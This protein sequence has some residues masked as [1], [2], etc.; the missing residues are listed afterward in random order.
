[1]GNERRALAQYPAAFDGVIAVGATGPDDVW[2][3]SFPWDTA[4]GSNFGSHISVC[5]PGNAIYG[6]HYASPGNYD[7]YWSG[8]S[9][10]APHVAGVCALL[11]AQDPARKPA[12]LKKLLE[13]GADDQVGDPVLDTPGFDTHYGHGRLNA[14]RSLA[15]GITVSL[16]P[17]V[18]SHADARAG[19]V[20][21]WP[22]DVLGRESAAN[23]SKRTIHASKS[24]L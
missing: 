15:A 24:G 5:A 3:K 11:L 13:A 9:Q 12:D 18:R 14:K 4:K 7:S 8:T 23:T 10:A 17:L 2:V 1:M 19:A 22:R 6:L 21:L 16:R 20:G